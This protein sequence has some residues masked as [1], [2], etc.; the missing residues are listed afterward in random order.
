MEDK[1]SGGSARGTVDVGDGDR[2]AN[3]A[4][5]VTFAEDATAA[6]AELRVNRSGGVREGVLEVRGDSGAAV[7]TQDGPR[8]E[9]GGERVARRPRVHQ[10]RPLLRVVSAA[11]GQVRADRV[12]RHLRLLHL[13]AVVVCHLGAHSRVLRRRDKIAG[14]GQRLLPAVRI[15]AAVGIG[16]GARGGI[17]G[18]SGLGD[19]QRLQRAGGAHCGAT[20]LGDHH[21]PGDGQVDPLAPRPAAQAEPVEQRGAGDL[22]ALSAHIRGAAGGAG[23][24]RREE[25]QGALCGRSV[26]HHHRGVRAGQRACDSGGH[27]SLAGP[28]F[29]QDVRHL[30]RG[31][32]WPQQGH[33]VAEL[34]SGVAAASSAGA[35][36]GGADRVARQERS[37]APDV[38]DD[39]GPPATIRHAGQV[40]R[41]HRA[42]A[43]VEVQPLGVARRAAAT[44]GGSARYRGRTS[45]GDA[46]G[47]R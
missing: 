3:G 15:G 44:G 11:G 29:R 14:R 17:R 39:R 33:A 38:S 27:E 28:E 47:H 32:R 35:S 42:D 31:R 4:A 16:E 43:R 5:S 22:G 36:G 19:A 30:V 34:V 40:R 10:G 21:I 7:A 45:A 20:D 41:P 26:H 12:L 1:R 37:G 18:R 9:G 8:Q 25:R 46:T 24:Q 6:V 23:H 13:P 2:A